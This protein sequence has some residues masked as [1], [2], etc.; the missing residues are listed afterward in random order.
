MQEKRQHS[1]VL[2][3]WKRQDLLKNESYFKLEQI[4]RLLFY[5][6]C[7]KKFI[8]EYFGDEEDLKNLKANCGLCD[9][10]LESGS[11]SEDDKK[12]FL[13]SSSYAVVLETVKKYNEKF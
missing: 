4:K 9:Y 12:K 5:P 11:I 7:R 10:C 13:P 3:D 6:G 1:H 2:I 8:L